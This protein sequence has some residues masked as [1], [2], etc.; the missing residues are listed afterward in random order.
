MSLGG[1][2]MSEGLSGLPI[3]SIRSDPPSSNPAVIAAGF[4]DMAAVG[5]VDY[6]AARLGYDAE[7]CIQKAL[8]DGEIEM[9]Q[10]SGGRRGYDVYRL[11]A[12]A[13]E[14]NEHL[15]YVF[16]ESAGGG[17]GAAGRKCEEE[18][19][20]GTDGNAARPAV[21]QRAVLPTAP[22]AATAGGAAS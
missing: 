14:A 16:Q 1:T 3:R 11:T 18:G 2:G 7:E 8:E 20:K 10:P 5:L 13:R 9:Y 15:R 21:P 22:A 4:S 19:V 6:A 17:G 12:R